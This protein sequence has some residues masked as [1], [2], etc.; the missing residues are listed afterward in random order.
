MYS[1]GVVVF[2]DEECV[3]V[4]LVEAVAETGGGTVLVVPL[5]IEDGI[6]NTEGVT[7]EV[8]GTGSGGGGG[9][10]PGSVVLTAESPEYSVYFGVFFSC[11]E[12]TGPLEYSDVSVSSCT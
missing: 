1:R 4:A 6:F 9:G 10:D 2:E 12:A 11:E 3:A 8:S 5:L 7:D